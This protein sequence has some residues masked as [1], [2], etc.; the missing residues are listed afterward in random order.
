MKSN[1]FKLYIEQNKQLV[2]T[3]VIKNTYAANHINDYI[4]L[5][6]GE[7]NVDYNDP[8]SWK[9]YMNL[10]GELHFTDT[11]M[12]ISSLDNG[13]VIEFNISNLKE[14]INTKIGYRY[15]SK[16]YNELVLK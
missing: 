4:S 6:H 1:K 5:M 3:I 12:Y 13:D 15:G 14:H 11:K 16:Y 9:Y 2:K 7:Q 10:S 8:Y